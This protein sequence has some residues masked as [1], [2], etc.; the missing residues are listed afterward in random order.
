MT[1]K[2]IEAARK[3]F[4]RKLFSEMTDEERRLYHEL[5]WRGYIN[6]CLAYSQLY[7]VLTKDGHHLSPALRRYGTDKT[8]SIGEWLSEGRAVEIA[9]EQ[10]E[11]FKSAVV[12]TNVYT[13]YEGCSYNSV[14][15]PD[16]MDFCK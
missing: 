3:P 6:S 13:D 2:E 7:L 1:P 12:H 5:A 4:Y 9:R 8:Y 10:A 15:Y 14:T 11:T 16:D